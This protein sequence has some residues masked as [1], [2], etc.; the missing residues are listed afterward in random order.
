[1][2]ANGEL[3]KYPLTIN[4]LKTEKKEENKTEISEENETSINHQSESETV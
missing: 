1:K 2:A 4:F 3:Y